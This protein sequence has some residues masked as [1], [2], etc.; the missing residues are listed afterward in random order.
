MDIGLFGAIGRCRER[1]YKYI[2]GYLRYCVICICI[3]LGECMC[4]MATTLYVM[5]KVSESKKHILLGCGEREWQQTKG[6]IYMICI[7]TMGA[8]ICRRGTVFLGTF[9]G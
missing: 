6:S 8:C 1:G 5:A 4:W 9:Y 3:Y 2:G 7:C